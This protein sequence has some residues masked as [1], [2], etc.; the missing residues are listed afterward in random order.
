MALGTE[1]PLILQWGPCA[2]SSNEDFTAPWSER[3]C[4]FVVLWVCVWYCGIRRGHEVD[5]VGFYI[6][7]NSL[8][9]FPLPLGKLFDFLHL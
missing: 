5:P 8:V 3:R 1:K 7:L 9:A 6:L 4:C 2:F